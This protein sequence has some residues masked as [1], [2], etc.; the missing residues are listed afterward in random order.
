[1][2]R[3]NLVPR[4]VVDRNGVVTTRWIKPG[5]PTVVSAQPFPV[6]G[7]G[8]PREAEMIADRLKTE[9]IATLKE[10]RGDTG[11]R[12]VLDTDAVWK[13]HKENDVALLE[14]ML[15]SAA[16]SA[17]SLGEMLTAHRILKSYGVIEPARYLTPDALNMGHRLMAAMLKIQSNRGTEVPVNELRCLALIASPDDQQL[18]ER[19]IVEREIVEVDEVAKMLEEMKRDS[20]SLS[21]GKL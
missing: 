10:A 18:I 5:G 6:P 1:M 2:S 7:L 15:V 17:P 20:T 21:E 13:A 16:H 3:E 11:I 8:A 4:P 12:S 14:A 9:I 19:I